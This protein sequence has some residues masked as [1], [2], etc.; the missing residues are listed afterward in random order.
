MRDDTGLI[1]E[2]GDSEVSFN[3]WEAQKVN[4][5]VSESISRI[6]TSG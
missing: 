5:K 6:S 1:A 3:A 2:T 4:S